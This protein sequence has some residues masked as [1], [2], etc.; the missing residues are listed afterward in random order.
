MLR[1]I[2]LRNK[3]KPAQKKSGG[4]N[5][6][7]LFRMSA[8]YSEESKSVRLDKFSEFA[9]VSPFVKE[10]DQYAAQVDFGLIGTLP[11]LCGSCKISE[12]ELLNFV[13]QP[14]APKLKIKARKY[15][16]GFYRYVER[17][18]AELLTDAFAYARDQMELFEEISVG[19]KY[20]YLRTFIEE[21]KEVYSKHEF[22]D[23]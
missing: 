6:S 2:A 12:K 20:E 10:I 4:G 11:W 16:L 22:S 1:K 23:I 8:F 3:I 14:F 21:N 5:K 17:W 7:K 18:E 19:K 15:G 13:K 9:I